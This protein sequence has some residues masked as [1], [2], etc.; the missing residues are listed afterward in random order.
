MRQIHVAKRLPRPASWPQTPLPPAPRDP[1]IVR[2]HQITRVGQPRARTKPDPGGRQR[3]ARQPAAAR[4]TQEDPMHP[5]ILQQLVTDRVNDIVATAAD[6]RRARE[7]RR[8]RTSGRRTQPACRAPS[9]SSSLQLRLPGLRADDTGASWASRPAW[10][11]VGAAQL[12]QHPRDVALD[13]DFGQV[14]PGRDLRV[15]QALTEAGQH[16]GLAVGERPGQVPGAVAGRLPIGG[17][18]DEPSR[19]G[20]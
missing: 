18:H 14:Q 4:L 13:R 20:R 1:D 12:V 15:G 10:G 2:A 7:A 16:L 6:S 19:G 17:G 5:L 8:T 3:P 11:A 9:P